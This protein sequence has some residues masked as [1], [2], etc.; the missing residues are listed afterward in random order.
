MA[1]PA[2]R[3]SRG[4]KR[5]ER[6]MER[7]RPPAILPRPP[8]VPATRRQTMTRVAAIRIR[9]VRL[10]V[11]MAGTPGQ[12]QAVAQEFLPMRRTP[13]GTRRLGRTPKNRG[14]SRSRIRMRAR[15]RTRQRRMSLAPEPGTLRY[16]PIPIP[17]D[18]SIQNGHPC[19][20]P[21]PVRWGCW[22]SVCWDAPRAAGRLAGSD[23]KRIVRSEPPSIV[24]APR[25][26]SLP[27]VVSALALGRRP[28]IA[29]RAA[30]QADRRTCSSVAF[31]DTAGCLRVP[32]ARPLRR[33]LPARPGRLPSRQGRP[34]I[35]SGGD[36]R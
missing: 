24:R 3:S 20:C 14:R 32:R 15:K 21:S 5:R 17:K 29:H 34:P 7:R 9:E 27:H 25:R 6:R 26:A 12:R 22:S 28:N 19:R 18:R 35:P 23:R 10:E 33:A 11:R 1:A 13:I 31:N 2:A 16:P 4:R 36:R 8:P 30:D